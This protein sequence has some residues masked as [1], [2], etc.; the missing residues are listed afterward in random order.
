MNESELIAWLME[1]GGPVIRYR[2]TAELL[3][4]QK[5]ADLD[6]LVRELL[7]CSQAK[8][9]LNRL[10]EVM[11]LHG[12][13]N[14]CLENVMGKLLEFGLH[15]GMGSLDKRI[16]R[17][18]RW[19][20]SAMD[21]PAGILRLLNGSIVAA[22]LARADE[23]DSALRHFLRTRL[24]RLSEL[25][26]NCKYDIYADAKEYADIPDAFQGRQLIR[27]E[28]TPQGEYNLP[29]IHDFYAFSALPAGMNSTSIRRKVGVLVKYI[30]NDAYQSLPEGYG[31]LRAG[32][33]R[34]YAMGWSI[35]LPGYHG[36]DF[37]DHQAGYFVQRVE[38]MA[39]FPLA[40]GHR[41]FKDC[42]QH[43]D[44]F[45]T[46]AGTWLFPRRYLK[47]QRQGYWVTGSH[48]GLEENRR[49][50][51]SLELESTFRMLR[52]RKLG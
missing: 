52:I 4:D 37:A 2:T 32:K 22:G 14:D 5:G 51:L 23:D 27:P 20:A 48:M 9:W 34:Y 46:D 40:R 11:S 49:S 36:F 44:G 39:H 28:I 25:A 24:D 50:S 18:R 3:N 19:M 38:L 47:E 35:D 42:I 45:R 13:A 7:R 41:W 15:A 6:R 16:A 30:L 17:F 10:D 31:I 26:R 33:R 29:C 21:P 43:L 1:N 12:S 8:L